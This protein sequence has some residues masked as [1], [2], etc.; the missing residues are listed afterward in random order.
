M[1]TITIRH[2][3]IVSFLAIAASCGLT[4]CGDDSSSKDQPTQ[5]KLCVEDGKR[6]FAGMPQKCINETWV[7]QTPCE[8]GYKCNKGNCVEQEQPVLTC[9]DPTKVRCD[10]ICIDPNTN[11][12]YCGAKEGCTEA[13]ECSNTERCINGTCTDT[14]P[15]KDCPND[16]EVKCDGM[17]INPQNTDKYC[18]AGEKC[19]NAQECTGNEHCKDGSCVEESEGGEC[20]DPAKVL[21]G[22]SCID[23]NYS[24]MFC[25]AQKGCVGFTECKDDLICIDGHCVDRCASSGKIY[26][27]G[28]CIDPN[29]DDDYCGAK[30]GCTESERCSTYYKCTNGA[31]KPKKDC[32]SDEYY[33]FGDCVNPK[34]DKYYCGIQSDCT[35]LTL[36][37]WGQMCNQGVCVQDPNCV[38]ITDG[39]LQ[40]MLFFLRRLDWDADKNS[41]ITTSEANAVT[42]IPSQVFENT[43][44]KSLADFKQFPNIQS[45][46]A[47]AFYSCQ[48]LTDVD[49]DEYLSH[50]ETIGA[51]AFAETSISE[52]SSSSIKTIGKTAFYTESLK[53]VTLPNV[54]EIAESAFAQ[55]NNLEY[56]DAPK[57]KEFNNGFIST[58][59]S[60]K[61]KELHLT[62]KG[63]FTIS[64]NAFTGIRNSETNTTLY[65]NSD[66][67]ST[68]S[69][70][71]KVNGNKWG[72][73]TWKEIKFVD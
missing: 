35:G 61:L 48:D 67:K 16:G 20:P 13:Q 26:C 63:D 72:N 62:A 29:T 37:T 9:D 55:V 38:P 49:F 7:D 50:V 60:G 31:C 40:M 18:G 21:C 22:E 33:C 71:P 44:I 39:E 66:K 23:P 56:F 73:A 17:C 32:S 46:G 43:Y 68:G 3:T 53:R 5:D 25:G 36:C 27:N 65:L 1:K 19:I 42:E 58:S 24:K 45:I 28:S 34:T 52:V 41:C 6:C 54:T 15:P 64:T 47:N 2:L 57:L 30:T 11:D 69:A 8:D 12:R 59:S 14:T 70:E 10:N 4:S 51:S